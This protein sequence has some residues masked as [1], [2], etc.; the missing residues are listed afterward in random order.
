MSAGDGA[1]TSGTG[2][3]DAVSSPAQVEAIFRQM[4]GQGQGAGAL[5]RGQGAAGAEA[6]EIKK[7]LG[8]PMTQEPTTGEQTPSV[9]PFIAILPLLTSWPAVQK[10]TKTSHI[11][12]AKSLPTLSAKLV[13]KVQ[14]LE[15]VEMEFLPTPRSLRLAEQRKPNPSF[16]ESLGWGLESLPGPPTAESPAQSAAQCD[17]MDPLLHT[18]YGSGCED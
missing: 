17:D 9:N 12:I 2:E 1:S 4:Q 7:N 10:D 13:A 8:L 6:A 3:G 5:V 11:L 16:Q 18:I 15:F 14:S